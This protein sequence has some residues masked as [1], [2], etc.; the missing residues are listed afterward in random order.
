MG[1]PGTEPEEGAQ[2]IADI[3]ADDPPDG[4]AQVDTHGV[5]QPQI[6]QQDTRHEVF[7]GGG[8]IGDM[9]GWEA[10]TNSPPDSRG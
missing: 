10:G 7:G 4:D 5:V 9:Q 1:L 8:D 6:Q 2:Q 3:S